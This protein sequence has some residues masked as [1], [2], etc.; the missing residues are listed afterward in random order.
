MNQIHA[1]ITAP[2]QS[3]WS[4]TNYVDKHR[5]KNQWATLHAKHKYNFSKMAMGV[6]G[7]RKHY[8]FDVAYDWPLFEI[9]P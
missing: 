5:E 9:M 4:F 3:N 6:G 1:L 2:P 7:V 8:H